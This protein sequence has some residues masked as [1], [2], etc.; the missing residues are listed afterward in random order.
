VNEGEPLHLLI[1]GTTKAATTSLFA[2]LAA[3]P[4]VAPARIKETRYF[5]DADYPLAPSVPHARGRAAY[6]AMFEARGPGAVRLEAT[7]DYLHS[8]GSAARIHAELPRV[9]LVFS[10]RD[11]VARLSSWYRYA[12]AGGRLD[13][14]ESFEAWI[15]RMERASGGAQHDRALVQGRYVRDL[16]PYFELFAPHERLVLFHEELEALPREAVEAVCALAGLE[17]GFYERFDFEVHNANAAHR[18]PR[19]H[20]AYHRLAF[21]ARR[22]SAGTPA[23]FDLLRRMHRAVAPVYRRLNVV[24]A[25]PFVLAPEL[26]RELVDFYAEDV[27]ALEELLGRRVPWP[28]F[29]AR[30]REWPR[31]V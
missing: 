11:P 12:R 25:E 10:L 21:H 29:A 31:A 8:P 1:A 20:R 14:R 6:A 17:A 27:A 23:L 30:A 26:E 28:R 3:H 24:A 5:L 4:D 16:R 19:M 9:R 15:R 7:P 22:V 13:A 2:W 18:H